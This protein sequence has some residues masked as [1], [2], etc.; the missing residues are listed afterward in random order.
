MFWMLHVLV[1]LSGSLSILLLRRMFVR[2]LEL[3]SSVKTAAA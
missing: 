1:A 3:E 2:V